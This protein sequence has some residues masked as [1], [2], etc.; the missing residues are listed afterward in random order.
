MLVNIKIKS[1]K[2]G[3]TIFA[4]LENNPRVLEKVAKIFDLQA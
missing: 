1:C 2:I 3:D 4:M